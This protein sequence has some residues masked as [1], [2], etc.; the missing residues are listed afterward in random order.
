M[1]GWGLLWLIALIFILGVFPLYII[2][3]LLGGRVSMFRALLIKVAAVIITLLLSMAFGLV[4]PLIVAIVLILLYR[5]AFDMGIIRSFI[6]WLLEGVVLAALIFTLGALG[7][8][9]V[10]WHGITAAFQHLAT[11]L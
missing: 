11:Y 8:V 3:K 5:L 1:D 4:G 2:V 7:I 10:K 6:A 9:A